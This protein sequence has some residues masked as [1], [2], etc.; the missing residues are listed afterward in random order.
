MVYVVMMNRHACVDWIYG[1]KK[2]D[3]HL[4][5]EKICEFIPETVVSD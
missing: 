3:Q 5:D 1:A 2:S 4:A